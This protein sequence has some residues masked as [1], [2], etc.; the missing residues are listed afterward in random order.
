MEFRILG[1]LE[2]LEGGRALDLGGPKQRALLALLLLEANRVVARDRL[3]DA[4]WDES[5]PETAR[6]ALQV[7]VSQLRKL[8][9]HER[10]ATQAPG[11]VL[12]VEDGE[13]DAA[14]AATLLEADRPEDALQL[15]RGPPLADL[16]GLRFVE[17]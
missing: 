1:P 10:L 12:R 5:P 17:A 13:L 3:I 8:I 15:W 9:G 16:A 7:H 4:L 14:R 2:V 11:Y 6:K